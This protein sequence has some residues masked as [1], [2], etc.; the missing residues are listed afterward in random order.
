[1]DLS[2]SYTL[3]AWIKPSALSGYQTVLIKENTNGSGGCGYWLQTV[4]TQISSGF[5]NGG[6][7]EHTANA[8]LQTGFWYHI[9]AV[10]DNTANTY[11]IYLN[12]GLLSSQSETTAPIPNTQNLTIGRTT[13]GENWQ[14]LVDEVRIYN[15]ALNASEIQADMNTPLP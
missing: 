13:F 10:F 15:R 12:G 1:L 9:A 11:Q 6:C 4:G 14:G 3:T 7:R 5:Y 8:N 2:S